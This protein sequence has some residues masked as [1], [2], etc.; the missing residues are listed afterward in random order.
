MFS[1]ERSLSMVFNSS[2]NVLLSYIRWMA[3]WHARHTDAPRVD[4]SAR[5]KICRFSSVR[6]V[7]RGIKWWNVNGIYRSHNYI[8]HKSKSEY[9][10]GTIAGMFMGFWIWVGGWVGR[11]FDIAV[12]FRDLHR[13]DRLGRR[14]CLSRNQVFLEVEMRL[15]QW[16][17]CRSMD[18]RRCL[19]VLFLLHMALWL[20]L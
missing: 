16:Q 14:W 11:G 5:V 1:W 17:R 7:E 3:L 20:E 18:P 6:W 9:L 12:G 4:I 8:R 15:F 2:A 13:R 10:T 19:Q